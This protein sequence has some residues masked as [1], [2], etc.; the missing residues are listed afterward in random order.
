MKQKAALLL[1][2]AMLLTCGC[3]AQQEETP[4]TTQETS[5]E[6]TSVVSDAQASAISAG[7]MFS[8]RDSETD[9]DESQC[10]KITLADGGATV[11][12]LGAA[13]SGDTVTIYGEGDYLIT[14]SLSDGQIVVDAE[15]DVKLR[16]IL[17][18]VDV[19]SASSAAIYVKQAD[20]VFVTLAP[21]SE[22]SLSTLGEY[23]QT[24]DNNVDAV[25]FSKDD[26]TINGSGSLTLTTSVGHGIVSKDD[27][28]V[29]GGSFVIDCGDHGL[30]GKESVR[31][32]GG[33]FV[34]DA[35]TDGIH[36]NNEDDE[37]LGFVYIAGGDFVINCG[38]DGIDASKD[39][40]VDGG[41]FEINAGDDGMHAEGA[42]TINGGTIVIPTCY[43]G[44]EGTTVEINGGEI[45]VTA[46]DDAINAAAG[47][48]DTAAEPGMGD[49]RGMAAQEGV[50]LTINGGNI[51][52]SAGGDAIDSNGDL[53]VTGGAIVAFNTA[54]GS[55]SAIDYDG[56]GIVTGGTVLC[57]GG[58]GMAMGFSE[59]SEQPSILYGFSETFSA[60]TVV[61]LVDSAGTVIAEY[62]PD[63]DFSAVNISTPQLVQ[64][65][66]YT[67]TVGETE[68]TV[69]LTGTSYS[70]VTGGFGGQ[71]PGGGRWQMP[72]W[73]DGE[74]PELPE[75]M[76]QWEDGE[77]PQPPEGGMTQGEE[78]APEASPDA[79]SEL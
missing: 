43:E 16:L 6:N 35:V 28:V 10:V 67:L 75:D 45:D 62:T 3:A 77:Q 51:R 4:Q 1:A 64:G 17:D 22:N 42:L 59:E 71:R 26:L 56:T 7:D 72:Q 65:E 24:D 79:G 27:L 12:G 9:Y 60:G 37:S 78:A 66:T 20:K 61:T 30:N 8:D 23:V 76:P 11:T 15:K 2:A 21:G 70:N 57:A 31:I 19:S 48:S 52:L 34:I 39:V 73:E 49:R 46:D 74:M 63:R 44:I 5:A 36:S 53:T 54:M 55:D 38:S 32:G 13:V 33:S 58:S 68:Y 40:Q 50:S 25:I 18:G 69:E 14:G 47:S 29:M 41:N